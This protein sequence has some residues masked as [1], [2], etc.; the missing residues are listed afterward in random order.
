MTTPTPSEDRQPHDAT[1]PTMAERIDQKF[2]E[3]VERHQTKLRRLHEQGREVPPQG[4][5]PRVVLDFPRFLRLAGIEASAYGVIAGSERRIM[6]I[7][8]KS[9]QYDRG[10]Q[11]RTLEGLSKHLQD[12]HTPGEVHYRFE[13]GSVF[14]VDRASEMGWD[15]SRAT[16]TQILV[17]E[18]TDELV[19]DVLL[20]GW[21]TRRVSSAGLA[22]VRDGGGRYAEAARKM[23][24]RDYLEKMLGHEDPERRQWA[25]DALA[26][27]SEGEKLRTPRNDS[28]RDSESDERKPG[29]RSR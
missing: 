11:E 6:E 17:A 28:V 4:A 29:G 10:K 26:H 22:K 7:L 13:D 5:R 12:S 20:K 25:I 18:T 1:T 8:D 3:M 14:V 9:P 24:T 15:Q 16:R 19:G 21:L 2:Q 27:V 23:L